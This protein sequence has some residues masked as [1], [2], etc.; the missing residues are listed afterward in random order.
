[1]H[2]YSMTSSAMASRLSGMVRPS[3]LAVF[4][5]I[6]NWNWVGRWINAVLACCLQRLPCVVFSA[7]HAASSASLFQKRRGFVHPYGTTLCSNL[8]AACGIGGVAI[9]LF[10]RGRL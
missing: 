10:H 3:A 2:P 8:A 7:A 9:A 6:T 5:S 4:R 1:M